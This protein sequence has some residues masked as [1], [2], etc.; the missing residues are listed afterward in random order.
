MEQTPG[1]SS[2]TQFLSFLS[3]DLRSG[4]NGAVLM[5]EV[6][7]RQF[8]NKPEFASVVEDVE[9]V[10]RSI[11]DTVATMERFLHAEKLRHGRMPVH[12]GQ[13]NVNEFLAK[14][15]KNF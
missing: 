15:E 1:D 12:V 9:T 2:L 10:R 3:H 11:L 14:I 7:K 6:I 8:V 5:L 13:V 4:L